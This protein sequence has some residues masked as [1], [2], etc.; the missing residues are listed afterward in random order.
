MLTCWELGWVPDQVSRA[1]SGELFI[2]QN[3][4][5][6]LPAADMDDDDIQTRLRQ[7]LLFLHGWIRDDETSSIIAYN[8]VVGPFCDS[9]RTLVL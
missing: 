8:P 2:V 1:N 9:C 6:L 4:G 5:G 3:P 7:G